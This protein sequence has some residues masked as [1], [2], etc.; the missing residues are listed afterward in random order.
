[1]RALHGRV[2][3]AEDGTDNQRL[4]S[5]I[6]RRAGAEVVVAA[7]GLQASREVLAAEST[8]QPFDVVLMDMQMPVMD[9]YQAAAKLRRAGFRKP[10]VALT[11]AAMDN[12]RDEC[13]RAGCSH[14][15]AKP[16]ERQ[17]LLDLLADLLPPRP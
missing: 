8:A 5:A 12:D 10:I 2:L 9:G 3:L 13:M 6:L 14:F 7:N 4:I 11:A 17:V 15:A 1:M 16:V